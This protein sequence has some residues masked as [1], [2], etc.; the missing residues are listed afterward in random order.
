[1]EKG[2]QYVPQHGQ[3]YALFKSDSS[4]DGFLEVA[5][6]VFPTASELSYIQT[7]YFDAFDPIEFKNTPE[8][9]VKFIEGNFASP[10]F[11][12]RYGLERDYNQGHSL[13]IFIFDPSNPLD[14]I[15]LWNLRQIYR[16]IR[17]VNFNWLPF[18][19][20]TIK[21]IV[22]KNYRP[23]PN[24]PNG[25]MI[26][27]HIKFGR[28]LS[29]TQKLEICEKDLGD[30]NK[31]SWFWTND[32]PRIWRKET[33]DHGPS[34]SRVILTES[35]RDLELKLERSGK[36]KEL[37]V[38]FS[39]ISPELADKFRGH[40]ARWVNVVKLTEYSN[41][42]NLALNLPSNIKDSK[43]PN[44]RLGEPLMV[45]TEGFILPQKYK[46]HKEY[47]RLLT[48]QEAF[49]NWFKNNGV[50]AKVSEP[51][52][53]ANQIFAGIG[54]FW[55]IRLL[56][57]KETLELLD[58]MAKSV[59]R[60]S[61]LSDS[62]RPEKE[63]EFPE[64]TSLAKKWVSLIEKRKNQ[65][66]SRI[67]LDD[68][69]EAG[70]LKLG[71]EIEC[72]KCEKKNW[73]GLSQLKEKVKCDRCL[74]KFNFPQGSLNFKN[75]PWRYRVAGPFS[76]PDFANGA[77]ATLLT[78]GVFE[79][80]LGTGNPTIT[81]STNLNLDLD[82]IPIEIDFALWHT[83]EKGFRGRFEPDLVFGE[84]KSLAEV[85]FIKKDIDRMKIL[86]QKFP[87]AYLVF[88][89]LKEELTKEEKK[90][91]SKLAIWGRYPLKNG[92]PR[93]P[94]IVLTGTELFAKLYIQET[95]KKHGGK[96]ADLIKPPRVFLDNLFTLS[97]LTQQIYLDLP[98]YYTWKYK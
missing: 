68:F 41:K 30:L 31:D 12:N 81:F 45:S 29:E 91:I 11:V 53:I 73:F 25:I 46:G 9:W 94:V 37:N 83:R 67:S 22:K 16:Q 57:D 78:L 21:D 38:R 85:A 92:M 63:E 28:S 74:K 36:D 2:E 96:R 15:D 39:S 23:L 54:G 70:A 35:S 66:F 8:D 77:Y 34:Y 98:D 61:D 75:S 10:F 40:S 4:E 60:L 33:E 55:G 51:G 82:S 19:K 88:S 89:T 87:G 62:S 27:T 1:Y 72:P 86:G 24:N 80:G 7:A 93:S 26:R 6:G 49:I 17:P 79:S 71:L 90:L 44:L 52:R 59:R 95:W 76:A 65:S 47:L 43:T 14:L 58:D 84:T 5:F 32:Y 13:K 69:V 20:K 42:N 64:R 56:A 3:K 48:G 97:N 50:S 18:V